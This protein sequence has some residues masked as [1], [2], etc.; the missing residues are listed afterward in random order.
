MNFR[1]NLIQFSI[2]I[3]FGSKYAQTP[4]RSDE[5]NKFN[6]QYPLTG[7]ICNEEAVVVRDKLLAEKFQY[8]SI[9]TL[10][11]PFMDRESVAIK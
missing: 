7:D 11:I 2:R 1:K 6:M 3:I 4:G 9:T 5:F 10:L 8:F